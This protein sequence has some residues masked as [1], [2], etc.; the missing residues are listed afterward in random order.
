MTQPNLA[1]QSSADLP[2][3]DGTC[4]TSNLLA[5]PDALETYLA[6]V[7]RRREANREQ[8][9]HAY[10]QSAILRLREELAAA[11]ADQDAEIATEL[12]E[13][14]DTFQS[15]LATSAST[16]NNGSE[17]SSEQNGKTTLLSECLPP[18]EQ[19]Q[20]H[21]NG[22]Q[23]SANPPA[24][25][26]LVPRL[27]KA[28]STAPSP[29]TEEVLAE[30]ALQCQNL[31]EK[32]AAHLTAEDGDLAHALQSRALFCAGQAL[33]LDQ[34][35]PMNGKQKLVDPLDDLAASPLSWAGGDPFS[36]RH[37]NAQVWSSLSHLY[38]DCAAA[39]EA[40]DWYRTHEAEV[41]DHL[42]VDVL[43]AVA[44]AQ[45][46]LYRNP[47]GTG[48]RDDAL[49]EM[50]RRIRAVG[51]NTGFLR[52]LS[53]SVGE[54]E[55]LEFV[56]SS[57]RLFQDVR[58]EVEERQARAEREASRDTAVVAVVAWEEALEGRAI[59]V[60]SVE[61]DRQALCALLDACIAVGVSPTNI[62]VRA[63]ILDTAPVLLE[64][65]PK[66]GKF[67][68]AVKAE[69][70]KRSLAA[71]EV[72]PPE[73][74]AKDGDL[75]RL[76]GSIA[77]FTRGKTLVMLGGKSRPKVVQE[78]ESL[79]ECEIAWHDSDPG[80]KFA[81]FAARVRKADVVLLLKNFASHEIFYASKDAMAADGKH[82]VVLPSG[83]GVKQ[84]AYQLSEY[85]A[86]EI[87]A[88]G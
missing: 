35:T 38:E 79:L 17:V 44:A 28:T 13:V 60:E 23:P 81:K 9:R 18:L 42:R 68:E 86:R 61:N 32:I 22:A 73:V 37:Q 78:L 11:H 39:G 50:Y 25:Q 88:A 16:G 57:E 48:K 51:E 80:D 5:S 20:P 31:R 59:T 45:Q 14:L 56:A 29:A 12:Q 52:A 69:R 64:G 34:N 43:N 27:P 40:L 85:I 75:E 66:Y 19:G 21:L 84:V 83:Y 67:L 4:A 26:N 82:F 8:R 71:V 41:P 7:R 63:A 87:V 30:L 58:A 3:V 65:L 54:A 53:P 36:L 77:E 2:P 1:K 62:K 6:D 15:A 10:W 33:A 70:T 72:A 76:I 24:A 47:D 49:H 74:E 46:R 55:L